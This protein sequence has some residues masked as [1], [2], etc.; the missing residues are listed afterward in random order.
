MRLRVGVGPKIGGLPVQASLVRLEALN[1]NTRRG[2]ETLEV[3]NPRLARSLLE[4]S[5]ARPGP[6]TRTP[7]L[8]ARTVAPRPKES[9]VP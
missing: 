5:A 3:R 9:R 8:A 6:Q 2:R 7:G 4:A 1:P